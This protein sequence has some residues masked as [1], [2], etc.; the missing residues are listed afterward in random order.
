MKFYV[1]MNRKDMLKLLVKVICVLKVVDTSTVQIAGLRLQL[2]I[3][4]LAT[5]NFGWR[6]L[7]KTTNYFILQLVV[8][9]W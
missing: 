6:K 9:D 5:Q 4:N 3:L 2:K 1:A 7:R 8:H